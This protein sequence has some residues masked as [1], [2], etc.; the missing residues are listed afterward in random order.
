[1][2]QEMNQLKLYSLSEAATAM[3]IGRDTLRRLLTEGRIG[4]IL[5]GN[6]K[7]IAHQE[8]VRFQS[9]NT[10]RE[11]APVQSKSVSNQDLQ[12]MFKRKDHKAKPTCDSK[13]LLKK[14][15][16]NDNNGNSITKRGDPVYPVVGSL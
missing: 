16:R 11:V 13:Q 15:I 4:Y 14:I 3:G 6:S 2:S 10:I 9:E 5:V 12:K 1:M 8:L 7:R